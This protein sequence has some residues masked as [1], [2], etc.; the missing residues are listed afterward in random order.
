MQNKIT[1]FPS[2]SGQDTVPVLAVLAAVVC[3][4]AHAIAK[5]KG[6]FPSCLSAEASRVMQCQQ[7]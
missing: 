7:L 4:C 6:P 3:E 1:E 5:H 2:W